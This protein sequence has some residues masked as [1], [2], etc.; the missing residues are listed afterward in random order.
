MLTSNNPK[1]YGTGLIALDVVLGTDPKMPIRSWAGGTCGNVLA[2]LAFLGWSAF[3]IARMNMDI[4]SKSVRADLKSI[5]VSLDYIHSTPSTH[6][7]IVVQEIKKGPNGTSKHRFL[8]SCP[9]CGKY[10]PSYR[11]ITVKMAEGLTDSLVAPSVF[12]FD[13]I[14]RGA[15]DLASRAADS[16]AAIVFE[17]S[18]QSSD[19]L[20]SDAVS[21]AHIVKYADERVAN[22]PGAMTPNTSTLLEVQTLG[23]RGLRYR[24]R[25]GHGVSNWIHLDAIVAPRVADTCG[26]GDWCTAGL[27]AKLCTNGRTGLQNATERDVHSALRFGQSLASWS[28]GFEGARGGMYVVDRNTLESYISRLLNGGVQSLSHLVTRPSPSPAVTCPACTR[29]ASDIHV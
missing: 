9:N 19:K 22:V 10:L 4:A 16:G 25:I 29:E 7:P 14:S 8:W 6:T 2:L 24:H 3:P 28:C 12:F 13:R 11:A 18:A 17:P 15:L 20:L 26:A 27:I 5:G 1:I 21:I 23:S